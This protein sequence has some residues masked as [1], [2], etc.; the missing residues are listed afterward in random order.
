MQPAHNSLGNEDIETL[1]NV[2]LSSFTAS[3]ECSTEESIIVMIGSHPWTAADKDVI[4]TANERGQNLAHLCAQL[5]YNQLLSD[6][7]EWGA[8]IHAEDVNGWTP[9]DFARL[10]GDEEAAD[11]LEGDWVDNV[12]T[13]YA[14]QLNGMSFTYLRSH[15][16][17]TRVSRSAS[18][19]VCYPSWVS[20]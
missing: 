7:I 5:G 15:H 16:H 20:S 11:I 19:Q 6:I 3:G 17:C 18:Q 4:N 12:E 9:L 2:V 13:E 8:D 1:S 10:H 14:S